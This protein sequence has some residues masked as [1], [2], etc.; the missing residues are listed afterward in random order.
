VQHRGCHQIDTIGIRDDSVNQGTGLESLAGDQ[1]DVAVDLGPLV[2]GA[3][4]YLRI[5]FLD[6]YLHGFAKPCRRSVAD[7]LVRK[8]GHSLPPDLNLLW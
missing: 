6:E 4:D 8:I 7:Q 3:T 5:H 1:T 2:C